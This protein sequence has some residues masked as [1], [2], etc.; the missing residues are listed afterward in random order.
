MLDGGAEADV[1]DGGLGD[2]TYFVDNVNDVASETVASANDT[3]KATVSYSL[4][5]H[6]ENLTLLGTADIDGA[7]N[8]LNNVDPR[9]FGRQPARRLRR[10]RPDLRRARQRHA[11][12]RASAST[13]STAA[14]ATTS[15]G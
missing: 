14:G 6:I 8:W 4:W 12:R 13:R 15:I 9:Q 10:R 11:G 1:M 2:D 5:A 3:V 7:G